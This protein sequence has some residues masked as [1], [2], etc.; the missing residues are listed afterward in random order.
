[1]AIASPGPQTQDEVNSRRIAKKRI[2]E[3]GRHSADND[4]TSIIN[5]RMTI[6]PR[7]K[8]IMPQSG[9]Q[10]FGSACSWTA[11]RLLT[12]LHV[13]VRCC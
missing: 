10:L 1:M 9:G 7:E 11:F 4:I 12:W 6:N 8:E 5:N 13:M 3:D 2:A